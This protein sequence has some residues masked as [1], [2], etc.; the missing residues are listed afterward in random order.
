MRIQKYEEEFE[1]CR[2]LWNRIN[3]YLFNFIDCLILVDVLNI[4]WKNNERLVV[5]QFDTYTKEIEQTTDVD[6]TDIGVNL[7]NN[8]NFEKLLTALGDLE[9]ESP[10]ETVMLVQDFHKRKPTGYMSKSVLGPFAQRRETEVIMEHSKEYSFSP[11]ILRTADNRQLDY[12]QKRHLSL[13]EDGVMEDMNEY[14]EK[15]LDEVGS[16][17]VDDTPTGAGQG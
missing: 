6:P 14:L 4:L 12:L 16:I 13:M 1:F 17:H 10:W 3:Q 15:Q 8:R 7:K 5:N 9:L 2:Q 11:K